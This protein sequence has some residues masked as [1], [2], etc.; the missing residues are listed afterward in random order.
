[1]LVLAA[2]STANATPPQHG[3][4]PQCLANYEVNYYLGGKAFAVAVLRGCLG[5]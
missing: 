2:G 5:G 3:R 4:L 1:M